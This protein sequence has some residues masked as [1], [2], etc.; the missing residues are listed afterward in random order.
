MTKTPYVPY[1]QTSRYRVE[2]MVELALSACHSRPDRES[3]AH[4]IPTEDSRTK[5]IYDLRGNDNTRFENE[6]EI[7]KRLP[8]Y[9]R[10]DS[11]RGVDLGAGDGRIVIAFAKV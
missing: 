5:G 4:S 6:S 8:R 1:F 9:A 11:L 7:S 10:N 2:T 3:S